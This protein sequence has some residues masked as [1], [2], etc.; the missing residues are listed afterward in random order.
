MSEVE[1]ENSSFINNFLD[2]IRK[3][4]KNREQSYHLHEPCFDQEDKDSLNSCIE[5]TFVSSTGPAI[6]QFENGIS[7]FT[8][9]PHTC[10][11]INGT[12]ALHLA[13]LVSDIKAEEEVLVPS[14]CFVATANAVSYVGATPH[15]VE[16][17]SEC[18]SVDP[19]LLDDYLN[20]NATVQ[21]GVCINKMTNKPIKSLIVMHT[22][23]YPAKLDELKEVCD[24]YSLI[25]IED[26]AEALGS[27][28]KNK[29]VGH[30]GKFSILSFNGNKV[31]TSGGGGMLMSKDKSS[32]DHVQLLSRTA[33]KA[34]AWEIGHTDIGYNYRMPNLNA[35]LGCSQLNKLEQFLKNKQALHKNYLS[36]FRKLNE[37]HLLTSSNDVTWNTWLNT[38]IL[39]P[40]KIIYKEEL[41]KALHNEKIYVRSAWCPLHTLDMYKNCP[42]MKLDITNDFFNRIIN[43]PSSAFLAS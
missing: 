1:S 7:E 43:L 6:E 18:L 3:V 20:E 38:C 30:H 11:V 27:F 36:Q 9:L 31:I 14:M 33:K 41:I 24:K 42:K 25:L 23:G 17:N 2:T 34:H 39:N 35:S 29:H 8:G 37:L 26:A 10:A 32:I 4:L 16:I 28:Y 15:F 22:F 12:S 13:L 40:D 5:S 21:S 19:V